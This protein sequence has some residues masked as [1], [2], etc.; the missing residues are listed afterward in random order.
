LRPLNGWKSGLNNNKNTIVVMT[1]RKHMF[2]FFKRKTSRST[3]N[4]NASKLV[5]Q[6]KCQLTLEE[7]EEVIRKQTEERKKKQK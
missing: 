6:G 3:Q 7:M 5:Q 2:N 4:N 1:I